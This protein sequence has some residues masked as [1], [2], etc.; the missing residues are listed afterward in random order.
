MKLIPVMI[1]FYGFSTCL[2]HQTVQLLS[3]SNQLKTRITLCTAEKENNM[4]V[5]LI[6]KQTITKIFKTYFE[7]CISLG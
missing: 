2:S 6:S 3:F 7:A 4:E 5:S 1:W